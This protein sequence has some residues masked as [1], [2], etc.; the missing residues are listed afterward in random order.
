MSVLLNIKQLHRC[1]RGVLELMNFQEGF[2]EALPYW[3]NQA[4]STTQDRVERAVQVDQVRLEPRGLHLSLIYFHCVLRRFVLNVPLSSSPCSLV[5]CPSS[6]APQQWTWCRVSS[7]SATCGSS[8][9][10]PTRRRRSCSWS[11]SQRYWVAP[12]AHP[13]SK[14]IRLTSCT[15][16][17]AGCV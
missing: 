2:R 1:F 8:Y 6:I 7:P 13:R 5:L 3:L 11:S 14:A 9:S 17:V 16:C 15:L 4:F 12:L 10:G